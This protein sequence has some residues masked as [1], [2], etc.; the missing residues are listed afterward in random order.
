M[1]GGFSGRSLEIVARHNYTGLND[2][3]DGEYYSAGRDQYYPAGYMQDYPYAS[4]SVGGGNVN[5]VTVGLN[6]SFN[7]YIQV[8]AD[9]TLQPPRPRQTSLRPQLPLGPGPRPVHLLTDTCQPIE[10]TI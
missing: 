6:F 8:M 4:S 10:H 1:L 3:V 9:Y 5:S 7:K 2:I